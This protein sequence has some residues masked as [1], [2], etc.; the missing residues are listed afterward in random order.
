MVV[1]VGLYKPDLLVEETFDQT[2]EFIKECGHD[3]YHITHNA[4][5]FCKNAVFSLTADYN[6]GALACT[7]D[8]EGSTSFECHPFGGQCQCRKDV[9]GRRC[10]ACRTGFYGNWN[11]ELYFRLRTTIHTI[12][13]LG[14]PDCKPCSCPSIAMCE[15]TTG[16]CMCPTNVI[17]PMCDK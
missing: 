15:A 1:P 11:D 5:E 3:H 8:H 12:S 10:T 7:C 17:G 6:S 9:I 13:F 16:E 14:F 4:S 2:K